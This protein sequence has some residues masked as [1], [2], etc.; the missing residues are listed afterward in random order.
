MSVTIIIIVIIMLRSYSGS[1]LGRRAGGK[2]S[3][4]L[5][6]PTMAPKAR[7]RSSYLWKSICDAWRDTES[8]NF[9]IAQCLVER[10][11]A[12][13]SLSQEMS[14]RPPRDVNTTSHH[15]F[16]KIHFGLASL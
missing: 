16:W 5:F 10:T 1:K 7:A 3:H 2:H 4:T 9:V 12:G 15:L 6:S 8:L 11:R 13:V 14:G